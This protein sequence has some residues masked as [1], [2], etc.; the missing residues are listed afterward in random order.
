MKHLP[1]ISL[2]LTGEQRKDMLEGL[3]YLIEH[4]GFDDDDNPRFFNSLVKMHKRLAE[5]ISW[6]RIWHEVPQDRKE[7]QA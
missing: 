7:E 4:D 6:E 5:G 3:D 2:T 1:S